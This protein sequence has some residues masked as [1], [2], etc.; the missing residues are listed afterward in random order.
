MLYD[1]LYYRLHRASAS[2]PFDKHLTFKAISAFS[3]LI[4]LNVF[5][6]LLL[7]GKLAVFTPSYKPLLFALL[8]L[9]FAWSYFKSRHALIVGKYALQEQRS[10]TLSRPVLLMTLYCAGSML[11]FVLAAGFFYNG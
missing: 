2:T 8:V 11:L 7:L 9:L 10:G 3:A 5:T 4:T 1:Y 6:V